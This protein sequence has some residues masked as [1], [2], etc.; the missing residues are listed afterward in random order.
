VR[1]N[2]ER[3][4][5]PLSPAYAA[6]FSTA[7]A[8]EAKPAITGAARLY[9]TSP[10]LV[11]LVRQL[12][13][14]S[15]AITLWRPALSTAI[16]RDFNG[17]MGLN[18]RPR[19]LWIDE[20]IAPAWLA[21]LINET[22]ETAAWIVVEQAGSTYTG[23]VAR[24][25]PPATEADWAAALTELGPQ[26]LLR[27]AAEATEADHGHALIAA[28]AGCH[29]LVDDRLDLPESLGAVRLPNKIAAWRQ[30]LEHAI[31]DLTGTLAHGKRARDAALALPSIEAEPPPW[32]RFA[33]ASAL[34][35]AA[36]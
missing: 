11:R 34:R 15:Q 6:V 1:V 36:E 13:A 3:A 2:P 18:T 28:A 10:G 17:G 16:W 20:G 7:P 32:A 26:I 12:A 29:L 27:P 35:S 8:P 21:E 14:P 4:A 23:A 9:A 25:H 30:A 5:L 24:I 31:R 19:V 22:L 33:P